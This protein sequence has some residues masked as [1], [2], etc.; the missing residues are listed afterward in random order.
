MGQRFST[1]GSA[2]GFDLMGGMVDTEMS[3][4]GFSDSFSREVH[5]GME[6]DRH[7]TMEGI[8]HPGDA[9]GRGS[10]RRRSGRHGTGDDA[11]RDSRR[12]PRQPRRQRLQP[13]RPRRRRRRSPRGTP[14]AGRTPIPT[15]HRPRTSPTGEPM[16]EVSR[17]DMEQLAER[18]YP[19]IR[20]RLRQELLIDRE[21]AGML[22]DFR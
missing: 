17:L 8:R 18:L 9:G 15:H 20:S 3:M 5:A 22:T 2:I 4:F 7:Q 11:A 16:V 13:R 14:H 21:R 10:S 6:H 19:N 1:L 12:G